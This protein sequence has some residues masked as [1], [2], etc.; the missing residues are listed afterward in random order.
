[1]HIF[2]SA[3]GYLADLILPP[4]KTDPLVRELTIADLQSAALEDGTLSYRDPRVRALIWELK[5]HASAP[6]LAL[7]GEYV[8]DLLTAVAS[9][10]IGKPLLIPIPM[11]K[12]RRKE[13]GHNQTEVLCEAALS[14][15]KVLGQ[16]YIEYA[17]NVLVR[18]RY[19]PSQQGLERNKRLINVENSMEVSYPKRVVGRVC[20]VIDD[21]STTGAT[22]KEAVRALRTAGARKVICI[23]LAQS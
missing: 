15:M 5:Y 17:P 11:H 13:R 20:V 23:A 7:A 12:K 3:F 14:Y 21:V 2:S 4:R 22:C 18:T 19:T 9:E 10:E 16:N 6:A 1:M 8:A